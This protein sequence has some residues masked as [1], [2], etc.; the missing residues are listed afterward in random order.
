MACSVVGQV[1]F[2]LIHIVIAL[3]VQLFKTA[4]NHVYQENIN[5]ESDMSKGYL[6]LD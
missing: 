5:K 2:L 3:C 6:T 1:V 4:I